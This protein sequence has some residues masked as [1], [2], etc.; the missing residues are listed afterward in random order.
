MYGNELDLS[1]PGDKHLLNQGWRSLKYYF[2]EV[3]ATD[4]QKC[5]LQVTAPLILAVPHLQSPKTTRR[6]RPIWYE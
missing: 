2:N 1:S 6:S 4:K 3:E 5:I